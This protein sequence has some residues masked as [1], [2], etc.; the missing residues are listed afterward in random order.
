MSEPASWLTVERGWTVEGSDGAKLG[1]VVETVGDSNLDIFNGLTVATGGL[2]R[3]RYVP[4][5]LVDEIR[6]GCVRLSIGSGEFER[7]EHYD[8]PPAS[9]QIEPE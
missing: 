9:E 6:E 3:A 5:E 2:S 8:E 4:S 1:N 7:L